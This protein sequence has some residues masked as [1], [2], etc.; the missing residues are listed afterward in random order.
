VDAIMVKIDSKKMAILMGGAAAVVGIAVVSSNISKRRLVEEGRSLATSSGKQAAFD[1]DSKEGLLSVLQEM[2]SSQSVSRQ[3]LKELATEAQSK[4]LSLS[5][6]CARCT[7]IGYQIRL[8]N[9]SCQWVTST[10]PSP[11]MKM[12][13]LFNKPLPP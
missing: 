11:S 12:I 7:Q 9:A 6:A 1:L 2:A 10:T 4:S 5:Q 8:P 3:Q 13:Q